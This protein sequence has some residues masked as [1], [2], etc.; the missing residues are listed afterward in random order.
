MELENPQ[1]WP[2]TDS[3]GDSRSAQ[4]RK[5]LRLIEAGDEPDDKITNIEYRVRP[6]HANIVAVTFDD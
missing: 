1:M 6:S 2:V 4:V 5:V 3:D